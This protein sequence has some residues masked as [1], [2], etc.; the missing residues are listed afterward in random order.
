M[1]LDSAITVARAMFNAG[2]RELTR[3]QLAGQMGQSV[4]SGN[5]VTKTATARIFG[6]ITFNQG[7]F[8][9]TDLGYAVVD[10]N[11]SVQ[12]QG[13]AEAFLSVPLYKRTYD[14]FR[15]KPLPPRPNGLEQAFVHFGVA[16]KQKTNA[17]LAFDKSAKQAGF[18]ANGMERLVP[19]II[20]PGGQLERSR[21]TPEDVEIAEKHMNQGASPT[22]SPA[23][24]YHPFIQGLLD[25]LPEPET[26]WAVEGRAK[27]LQTAANIFDLIY[28]GSGEITI[29]SK[30]K[31]ETPQN[32]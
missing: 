14:E 6:L 9:M 23:S 1:D 18:F 10:T 24:E 27:W 11:E 30:A 15:G 28:K 19:P 3:E 32:E 22:P 21:P 31:G 7:V 16:A 4:G 20:G 29:I 17:R 12:K 25:T 8:R 2:A 5:F 13:R 26:N